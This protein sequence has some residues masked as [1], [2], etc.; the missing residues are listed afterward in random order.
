MSDLLSIHITEPTARKAPEIPSKRPSAST[1]HDKSKRQKRRKSLTP[2]D[3]GEPST[4]GKEKPCEATSLRHLF[5]FGNS[6]VS[7]LSQHLTLSDSILGNPSTPTS[8]L[9]QSG[10][11]SPGDG[12]QQDDASDDEQ[13]TQN[14]A[15]PPPTQFR[16]LKEAPYSHPALA[17]DPYDDEAIRN[18]AA[19]FC[20]QIDIDDLEQQFTA[21]DGIRSQMKREFRHKRS[22]ALRGRKLGATTTT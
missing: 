16:L 22:N 20:R 8:T 10:L 5:S 3:H 13:Q 11:F 9:T 15:Q 17:Y 6:T 19:L 18:K 14:K 12:L 7:T 2:A 4:D 1:P 21:D